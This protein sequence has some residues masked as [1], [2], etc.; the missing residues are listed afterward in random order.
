MHGQPGD[1]AGCREREKG[2][3]LHFDRVHVRGGRLAMCIPK[4][5]SR[6]V[7]RLLPRRMISG[8]HKNEKFSFEV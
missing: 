8:H 6:F 7:V 5:D 1:E 3:E 4:F 2:K